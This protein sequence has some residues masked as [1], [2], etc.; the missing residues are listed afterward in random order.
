[1]GKVGSSVILVLVQ[2][3]YC[4]SL[5][6]GNGILYNIWVVLPIDGKKCDQWYCLGPI[7]CSTQESAYSIDLLA[8]GRANY[9]DVTLTSAI[10]AQ[11]VLPVLFQRAGYNAVIIL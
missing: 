6:F 2:P 8:D 7:L 3:R 4:R 5:K 10:E 11:R 9:N 1:M